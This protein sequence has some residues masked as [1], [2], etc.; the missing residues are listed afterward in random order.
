MLVASEKRER[1]GPDALHGQE[2]AGVIIPLTEL[3]ASP[4]ER[5]RAHFDSTRTKYAPAADQMRTELVE[6]A[7]AAEC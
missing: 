2:G 6:K 5:R 4:N 7:T 3:V 1:R